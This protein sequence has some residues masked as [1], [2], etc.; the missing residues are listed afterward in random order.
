EPDSGDDPGLETN[1]S[2]G[3]SS[4]SNRDTS[5]PSS[6]NSSPRT[7]GLSRRQRKNRRRDDHSPPDNKKKPKPKRTKAVV[8][9]HKVFEPINLYGRLLTSFTS[10][11]RLAMYLRNYTVKHPL[12]IALGYPVEF[13]DFPGQTYIVKD[14]PKM[15]WYKCKGT[16]H[17][18]KSRLDAN[19]REFVPGSEYYDYKSDHDSGQGSGNSS[20][21]SEGSDDS[22]SSSS[23]RSKSDR[24]LEYI[25]NQACQTRSCVR[26]DKNFHITAKNTYLTKE[27]CTYHWGKLQR[28]ITPVKH[29][30]PLYQYMCCQGSSTSPGC[31]TGRCHVWNGV[32]SGFNGPLEGFVYIHSRKPVPLEEYHRAYAL[33]CEMCYTV[34][35]LELAKVTVVGMDGRLVYDTFVKPAN[36]VV[37]YNTRFSGITAKDLKNGAKTLKEVQKDLMEFLHANT[38]LIGHGLENDLRALKIIH[39]D[40]IDTS[41]LFQSQTNVLPKRHSLKYLSACLL[42]K[43]IQ[44][45][46][47]GHNSYEDAR[48]AMELVLYRVCMDFGLHSN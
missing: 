8:V 26:C 3:S 37:D 40:C 7:K 36:D 19:A 30:G 28:V 43:E 1:S 12:L 20:D 4:D 16:Y 11:Q 9:N 22:L 38:L 47:N 25:D 27:K 23:S 6:A 18:I 44:C 14:S 15:P 45:G 21:S 33:D 5:L 31:T 32:K 13:P 42:N 34:E 29:N 39:N 10:E 24:Y 46:S 48:T 2:C 41:I 17:T 35:G